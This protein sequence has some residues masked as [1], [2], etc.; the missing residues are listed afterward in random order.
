MSVFRATNTV[1]GKDLV[2]RQMTLHYEALSA[3]RPQIDTQ[4]PVTRAIHQHLKRARKPKDLPSKTWMTVRRINSMRFD[5]ESEATK[6]MSK[7]RV[8]GQD[9]YEMKEHQK[10]LHKIS[11]VIS[12]LDHQ[13]IHDRKKNPFDPIAFPVTLFR[14]N[15]RTHSI[16]PCLSGTIESLGILTRRRDIETRNSLRRCYSRRTP[17]VGANRIVRFQIR[18]KQ[19]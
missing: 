2:L 9:E 15:S 8:R 10:M 18:R 6:S 16:I 12:R 1:G 11:N 4:E 5:K 13:S 19:L 14:R 17:K 3:I 7:Q